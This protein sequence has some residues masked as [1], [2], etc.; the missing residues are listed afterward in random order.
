MHRAC[1]CRRAAL[2]EGRGRG[3]SGAGG[4]GDDD[5]GSTAKDT[6]KALTTVKGHRCEQH[7]GAVSQEHENYKRSIHRNYPLYMKCVEN[8][9]EQ[10][11][12]DSNCTMNI[13]RLLTM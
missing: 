6:W 9:W 3:G 1:T 5:A 10:R 2:R 12:R 11:N 13:P 8:C 7:T 4:G